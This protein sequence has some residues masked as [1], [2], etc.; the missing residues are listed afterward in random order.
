M[1][2]SQALG[3]G[4]VAEAI[5]KTMSELAAMAVDSGWTRIISAGGETSGAVTRALGYTAFYIGKS[6]APGV[7]VM[8]P[9]ERP[10]LRIVLKS[11]GFGQTDFF[12]RAERLTEEE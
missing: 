3:Q 12:E 4:K 1:R 10:E 11:G 6:A 2:A 9:V 5:E 8:T 7:P